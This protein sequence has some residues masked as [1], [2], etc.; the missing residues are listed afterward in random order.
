MPLMDLSPGVRSLSL[1]GSDL[2]LHLAA[3]LA[4]SGVASGWLL[5]FAGGLDWANPLRRDSNH[6]LA[7][8]VGRRI[9]GDHRL[10][11]GAL[12]SGGFNWVDPT[13]APSDP[14]EQFFDSNLLPWLQPALVVSW[15]L[16]LLERWWLRASLGPVFGRWTAG[17]LMMPWIVPAAELAYRVQP[18]QELVVSGGYASPNGV[19]WRVAF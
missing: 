13:T 14:T 6:M 16:P 15:Q 3:D 19:A 8:R 9:W 10:S 17:P 7:L 4:L 5:G 11:V 12:L 1:G 18:N 2:T